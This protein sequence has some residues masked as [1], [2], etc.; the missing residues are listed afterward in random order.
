MKHTVKVLDVI[1]TRALILLMLFLV[2]SVLWQVI[3]RYRCYNDMLEAHIFC[4]FG[5][6]AWLIFVR[7]LGVS[8]LNRAK[9]TISR[10]NISQD[11]ECCRPPAKTFTH[12]GTSGLLTYG[13]Q[14]IAPE[15]TLHLMNAL[16]ET[17][18]VS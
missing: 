11:K 2:G 10:A 6:M 13:V 14:T 15:S 4:H 1:L 17:E 5:H 8:R 18:L 12:I 7:W 9:S 3:S 16:P